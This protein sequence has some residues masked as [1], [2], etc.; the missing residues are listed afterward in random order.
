VSREDEDEDAGRALHPRMT[1]ALFG[2][3]EAERTLLDAY[4]SGRIPHAW[5]LGGPAGIG[6]ATLAYRMARFV[7]AHPD[8][9]AAGVRTACSLAVDPDHP[10]ARQVAGQAHP[11]LLVLERTENE[12]GV[13][14][15]VITVEQV[16]RTVSFFGSTAGAGGWRVCV[17]DAADELNPSG[18]N[19]LLKVLEEP[20]P[21]SLFLVVS[22]APGRLLPTIRSR[23]RRLDLRPLDVGLVAAAAA[24]ATG[25]RAEDPDIQ[26]AA[27][28]ADGSVGRAVGLIGS[29]LALRQ[30]VTRL[31]GA[32]PATDP[33]ALHAL[34][35]ALPL[36]DAGALRA[37]AETVR[38]WLSARLDCDLGNPER[39]QRVAEAWSRV[40]QATRQAEEYNLDRKPLVFA[41]F[42]CLAEAA[43]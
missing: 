12:N 1:A 27:R 14:R 4:A 11:D 10:V 6:K 26:A 37:F 3:A 22:H 7:L 38:E 19:K 2:H 13:L 24:A 36:N 21:R 41:V 40:N 5:L 30:Q 43:R 35:E 33:T 15:T 32:L 17:V 23:C 34:G 31:L 29:A 39:L 8:P 42:G 20:P 9:G 16:A 25:G 28:A 18:A